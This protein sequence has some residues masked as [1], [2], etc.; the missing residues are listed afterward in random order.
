MVLQ[1]HAARLK[2]VHEIRAGIWTVQHLSPVPTPRSF[3]DSFPDPQNGG[4]GVEVAW[5]SGFRALDLKSG[6]PWL[7][8][9]TLSL[10]GFV[11]GRS[12]VQLLD[13]VC[14]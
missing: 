3:R 14:K 2:E 12:R 13:R 5:P 4:S 9:F 6:G 10:S 8:S 1:L 7:K 11:L